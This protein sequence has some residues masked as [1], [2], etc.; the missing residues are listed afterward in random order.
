[1]FELEGIGDHECSGDGEGQG[2]G[3]R[4]GRGTPRAVV[5]MSTPTV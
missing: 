4:N 2:E 5:T 3:S 1:M